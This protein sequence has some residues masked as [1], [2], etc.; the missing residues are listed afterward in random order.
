MKLYVEANKVT[1]ATKRKYPFL[2]EDLDRKC[3]EFGYAVP[4][5][6][7]TVL[8]I[9]RDGSQ[10]L[11]QVWSKNEGLTI[12]YDPNRGFL[13]LQADELSETVKEFSTL[14]AIANALLSEPEQEIRWGEV[15][16][17]ARASSESRPLE[18][19]SKLSTDLHEKLG[20]LFEESVHP[21]GVAAYSAPG[22][23]LD[24]PL[25]EISNWFDIRIEPL[26]ANPRYYFIRI[27]YR[28]SDLEQVNGYLRPLEDRLA[29]A[30]RFLEE[31]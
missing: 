5:Q 4:K 6:G 11:G 25:N 28:K 12:T 20:D 23:A 2:E 7:R 18:V 1:I 10:S 26:I 3:K 14:V 8:T 31:S 16:F 19:F 29:E 17:A 21:F 15:N 27:I 24:K 9:A 30:I 22:E 13:S